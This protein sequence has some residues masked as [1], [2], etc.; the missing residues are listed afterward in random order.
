MDNHTSLLINAVLDSDL[1]SV[2]ELSREFP[3]AINRVS[4]GTGLGAVHCAIYLRNLKILKILLKFGAD[5]NLPDR[6][7]NY[8]VHCAAKVGF[9]RALK[10][11]QKQ[12]SCN[13]FVLN[14]A[15]ESIIDIA[16]NMPSI[17]ETQSSPVFSYGTWDS[18]SKSEFM[19]NLVATRRDCYNYI[20]KVQQTTYNQKRIKSARDMI[21]ANSKRQS[22]SNII[23]SY[24]SA[25][26]KRY[27]NRMDYPMRFSESDWTENDKEFFNRHV[28]DVRMVI[29]AVFCRDFVRRVVHSGLYEVEQKI[30]TNK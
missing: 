27:V 17:E 7:N 21:V 24:N 26:E 16:G 19:K 30:R 29:H 11:L 5:P 12:K 6:E 1:H 25:S 9:V 20:L 10:V 15:G 2:Q 23:R 3:D 4:L 22:V 28:D 14:A 18:E 13:F 8:P